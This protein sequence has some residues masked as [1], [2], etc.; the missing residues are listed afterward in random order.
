MK[1]QKTSNNIIP[2]ANVKDE[3]QLDD[4]TAVIVKIGTIKP[5]SV[6]RYTGPTGNNDFTVEVQF[7]LI[8]G[9]LQP[10]NIATQEAISVQIPQEES[11][12]RKR[13]F[14]TSDTRA[15]DKWN[16]LNEG[17]LTVETINEWIQKLFQRNGLLNI[18]SNYSSFTHRLS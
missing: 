5:K 11:G 13:N 3:T 12:T 6:Y 7:N 16:S 4:F 14:I 15:V 2:C 8:E 18:K 9:L 17:A 1:L 10:Y